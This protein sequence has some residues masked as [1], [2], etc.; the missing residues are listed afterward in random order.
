MNKKQILHFYC[1]EDV[2]IPHR[3]GEPWYEIVID[4]VCDP[5][6]RKQ[7][8]KEWKN[9]DDISKRYHPTCPHLS[10]IDINDPCK[11]KLKNS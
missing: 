8:I 5:E 10:P 11:N 9:M 2:Y 4:H 7:I 6:I 1:D 3:P